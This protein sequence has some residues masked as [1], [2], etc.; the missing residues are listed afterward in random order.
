M[1]QR[2]SVR[3]EGYDGEI[4]SIRCQRDI[5]KD[6]SCITPHNAR[7]RVPTQALEKEHLNYPHGGENNTDMRD[8]QIMTQDTTE[9]LHKT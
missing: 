4:R 8:T 9:A 6:Y 7:H 3:S 5:S 1:R 2:Q